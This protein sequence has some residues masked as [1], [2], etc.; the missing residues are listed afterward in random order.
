M[1]F[2][3]VIGIDLGAT[4]VRGAIVDEHSVSAILSTTV[5]NNETKEEVLDQVFG[6]VENL[7]E[8][9]K[10]IVNFNEAPKDEKIYSRKSYFKFL[11]N[12]TN[13]LNTSLLSGKKKESQ[14]SNASPT[15]MKG[16][17]SLNSD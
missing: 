9:P 8:K 13:N 1:K 14:F 11:F 4:N 2:S 12:G 5:M 6:V 10:K 17:G 3:K 7:L 15:Q 16:Y